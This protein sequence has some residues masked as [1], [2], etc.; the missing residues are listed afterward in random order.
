MINSDE[1]RFK[2]ILINLISNAI[3]FTQRGKIV[4]IVKQNE[5]GMFEISVKDN[6]VGIP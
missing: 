5:N 3:K 4:S 2:Q 1:N 6:G